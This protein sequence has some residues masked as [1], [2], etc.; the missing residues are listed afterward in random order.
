MKE[1]LLFPG[2]TKIQAE[3]ISVMRVN[4]FTTWINID[5]MSVRILALT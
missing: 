1:H 3:K 4:L 2:E 5:L